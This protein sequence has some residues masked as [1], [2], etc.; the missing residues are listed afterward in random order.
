MNKKQHFWF[1]D[2]NEKT[3]NVLIST[4]QH[5]PQKYRLSLQNL[6]KRTTIPITMLWVLYLTHSA[7]NDWGFLLINARRLMRLRTPVSQVEMKLWTNLC[8]SWSL[9]AHGHPVN[10]SQVLRS[11]APFRL[12]KSYWPFISLHDWT[13]RSRLH[14]HLTADLGIDP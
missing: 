6:K 7:F 8:S 5:C 9:S 10:G 4:Q 13:S 3:T 11:A 14:S 1:V 2:K 12:I